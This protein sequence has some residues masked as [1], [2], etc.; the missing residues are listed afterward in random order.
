VSGLPTVSLPGT[1]ITTSVLGFGCSSLLGP[2]SA[3][4]ALRLLET[5]YDAGIRHFDVARAYGS[6]DVEG[7]LGR[8]MARR[9]DDVTV[10]TKFGMQPSLA[11]ARGRFLVGA[12]RRAMKVSPEL[13][14]FLGRQGA[15][16]VKRGAFS[17]EE[18]RSSLDASL[19]ELRTDYV[20]V[21][22]LHDCRVEDCS[23][24]L[25]EFLHDA[26]AAGKICGFG[27]GTSVESAAAI[28]QSAP[29]FAKV[30]QFE[31]SVLR[32]ATD[33]FN[34]GDTRALLTHGALAGFGALRRYLADDPV[35]RAQWSDELGADCGQDPILAA[36]ML[37]YA[38]MTNAWGPV[39]F[40][41]TR[42]ENIV[43]NAAAI[44]DGAPSLRVDRFAKLVAVAWR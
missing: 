1:A 28:V 5:A 14:R 10:T 8:F 15:R 2:K 30:L 33:E 37:N 23:E 42:A 6:G 29:D 41:S 4:E 22:L 43:G 27:V 24:G 19:S 21:L 36:L 7:V 35:V 44:A 31:H 25:L 32:P 3:A 20:D 39:L 9:R 13:R 16:L 12:A 26:A 34:A 17:V 40:S 38:V 18:A 11:V